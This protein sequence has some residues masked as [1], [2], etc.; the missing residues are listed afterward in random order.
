MSA[1]PQCNNAITFEEFA[2]YCG[3]EQACKHSTPAPGAADL[4]VMAGV[5]GPVLSAALWRLHRRASPVTHA[6]AWCALAFAVFVVMITP[7]YW[8]CEWGFGTLHMR[9]TGAAAVSDQTQWRPHLRQLFT[10]Q[11]V[12]TRQARKAAWAAAGLLMLPD[13]LWLAWTVL[14]SALAPPA[15]AM[16]MAAAPSFVEQ[17]PRPLASA[18]VSPG[19][20]ITHHHGPINAPFQTYNASVVYMGRSSSDD[21]ARFESESAR[22]KQRADAARTK[23]QEMLRKTES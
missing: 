13:A 6:L 4:L 10:A 17:H 1:A 2:R 9:Y 3:D 22:R 19:T 8:L 7:S 21:E 5:A 11:V 14:R 23:L 18:A 15:A 16:G 12:A 20:T